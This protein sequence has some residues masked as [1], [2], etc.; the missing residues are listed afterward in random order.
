MSQGLILGRG[1]NDRGEMVG[2]LRFLRRRSRT[3]PTV[4]ARWN[5]DL[6]TRAHLSAPRHAHTATRVRVADVRGP[7]D[8]DGCARGERESLGCAVRRLVGRLQRIGP[9]AAS[10]LFFSFLQFLISFP[11]PFEI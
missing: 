1:R 11:F 6:A 2:R 4:V 10:P 7:H 3:T 9:N 5:A 8:R